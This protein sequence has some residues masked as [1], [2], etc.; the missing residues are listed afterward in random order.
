MDKGNDENKITTKEYDN[1]LPDLTKAN[2]ILTG[3]QAIPN[4]FLFIANE[5]KV[6]QYLRIIKCI[7]QTD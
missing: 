7:V 1:P 4:Y 2:E 5:N 3:K 6:H